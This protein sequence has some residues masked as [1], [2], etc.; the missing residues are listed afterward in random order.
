MYPRS[1]DYINIGSNGFAQVGRPNYS[2]KSSAEMAIILP[3]IEKLHPVPEE[4]RAVASI[5]VKGFEHEFGRYH[6]VVIMYNRDEVDDW[7]DSIHEDDND[8][9]DRFYAWVN[10]CEGVELESPELTELIEAEYLQSIDTEK[11]EHLTIS[12]AA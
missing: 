4:F 6:E 3:H 11:G 9:H 2:R 1:W 10:A 8:K 12:K 7:E 5:T